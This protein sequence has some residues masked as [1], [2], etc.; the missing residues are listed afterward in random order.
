M[1]FGQLDT[2]RLSTMVLVLEI[3]SLASK[4]SIRIDIRSLYQK[5][6]QCNSK[7]FDQAEEKDPYYNLK[8][9]QAGI[10]RILLFYLIQKFCGYI[11]DL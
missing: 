6:L 3:E 7:F 9:L 1:I 2:L 5:L 10:I 8:K 4:Q 11:Q